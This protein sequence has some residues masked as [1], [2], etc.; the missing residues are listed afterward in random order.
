[1][2][3]DADLVT[4]GMIIGPHGTAGAVR[5]RLE[6][7]HPERFQRG[8]MY[9]L[10][11]PL[12]DR[13]DVVLESVEVRGER[14]ILRIVDV[15]TRDDAMDLKGR[16]LCVRRS[17]MVELSE[18]EYWLHDVVGVEVRTDDDELLGTVREI[19]ESPAHDVLVI[20]TGD[21]EVL[22]PMVAALV[23]AVRPGRSVVLSGDALRKRFRYE[24]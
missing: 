8:T 20:D 23:V 14:A 11:P 1:M 10:V 15:D 4:V 9:L 19:I 17:E 16:A 24:D 18:G 12:G 6:T 21:G 22:L 3:N 2:T 5:M 7:D 13:K